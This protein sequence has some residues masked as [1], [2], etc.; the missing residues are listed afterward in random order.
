MSKRR[1]AI[2]L[3]AGGV[4]MAGL[5]SRW[6]GGAEGTWNLPSVQTPWGSRAS[7]YEHIKAHI[8]PGKDGL[9]KGGDRL[10]D[11]DEGDQGRM[12]WVSGGIDGAFSH[13]GGGGQQKKVAKRVLALLKKALNDGTSENLS[14]FYKAATEAQSLDFVDP[15]IVL[16]A[17]TGNS[18][19]AD[20]LH[21]LALWMATKAA[22]REAV[23][24]AV[25]LLGVLQ[26]HDDNQVFLTV[27]RHEE[28][29]LYAAVALTNTVEQPH[30]LLWELTKHVDG[31]GRIHLVERLA[32]TKDAEIRGWLLRE[33]YKNSVMYE[34]L[35]YTCAMVGGLHTELAKDTVEPQVFDAAG[36][37]LG[38]LFNGGPAQ[39]IDDY[40]HSAAAVRDYVRHAD[41]NARSVEH[42]IVVQGAKH[43]LANN[44]RDWKA[45]EKQGWTADHRGSLVSKVDM[46]LARPSWRE[47]VTKQLKSSDERTFNL[48]SSAATALGIDPWD[49]HFERLK[50]GKHHWYRVMQTKDA[51]RIARVV[52]YAEAN[53]P[54]DKIATGPGEE[55][56]LGPEWQHHGNLDFVLQDLRRFPGVGW[57]LIKTGMKSPVIRNRHM[58]I[59]ALAAQKLA[60]W[61]E[62][63]KAYVE[64]CLE[65]EPNDD[66]RKAF[67][68][69]L[70]EKPIR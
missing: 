16:L 28:F 63:A 52:E 48:A 23:K 39:D 32:D 60:E 13:H 9:E 58:A 50:K 2:G 47:E 34:Y 20:R 49:H 3:V 70:E 40:E 12:K 26:G 41:T 36:D 33:G 25:A 6:L 64:S 15:L 24:L 55:M 37:I 1:W 46:I 10:P 61:P 31:W 53:I 22:D 5:L 29:T 11:E 17:K 42:L 30:R 21:E 68:A 35:A 19:N 43:F 18:L 51:S 65:A 27:G 45:R 54:L 44:D 66:V 8:K 14:A 67:K 56:G 4:I 62:G 57:K 7:I 69:L 59:R 38:A